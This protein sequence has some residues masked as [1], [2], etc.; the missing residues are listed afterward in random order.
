MGGSPQYYPIARNLNQSQSFQT[1][2]P[3]TPPILAEKQRML[4][5]QFNK[6]EACEDVTC[7]VTTPLS[8]Q[9]QAS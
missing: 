4:F 1:F 3:V 6:S 7:T 5:D 2:V 8:K 9:T